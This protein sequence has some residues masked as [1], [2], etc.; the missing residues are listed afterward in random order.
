VPRCST[1]FGINERTTSSSSV[2]ASVPDSAQRL[3]AST[4]EPLGIHSGGNSSPLCAQRLSASTKEPLLRVLILRRAGTVLNAFRHQRK[5]HET[6]HERAAK[7]RSAQRLSASTKEPLATAPIE[8]SG[9]AGAQRLSA[10]TKEPPYSSCRLWR[11]WSV[12]NAFRH[13]RKNHGPVNA[14]GCA[15]Q[16]VLNA[17]RHQRKNHADNHA[18]TTPNHVVLNAFRHQ[19]KNHRCPAPSAPS[20]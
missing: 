6:E 15:A 17:F 11:E 8:V 10:S 9:L 4:K 18:L 14:K 1:P 16:L 5:N 2:G 19:R 12:L 3:S 7:A 13:Q 20:S